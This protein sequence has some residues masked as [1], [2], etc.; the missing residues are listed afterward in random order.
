MSDRETT[1]L[2]GKTE[3]DSSAGTLYYLIFFEQQGLDVRL[4]NVNDTS[5]TTSFLKAK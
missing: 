1:P 4:K 2:I 5:T 3:C